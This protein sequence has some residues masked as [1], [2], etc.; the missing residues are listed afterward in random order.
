MP[1]QIR[2]KHAQVLL[3]ESLRQVLHDFLVRR[4]AM[5]QHDRPLSFVLALIDNVRN[6]VATTR[7]ECHG[8]LAVSRPLRQHKSHN[9]KHRADA[10]ASSPSRLH[11]APA[12]R[13][14]R[15][16]RA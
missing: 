12:P 1:R 14:R 3:R 9:A 16:S 5:Q 2:D 7:I 10:Q 11:A 4:Q 6:Q 15:N 8:R 13:A